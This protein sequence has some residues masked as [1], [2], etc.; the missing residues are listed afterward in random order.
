MEAL[1]SPDSLQR[2]IEEL[3]A[4]AYLQDPFDMLESF[5]ELLT[6]QEDISTV[7]CAETRVMPG[8]EEGTTVKY[9]RWQTPYNIAPQD[10]LDDLT[11]T[12]MI[13]VKPSRSGGTTIVENYLFK[14]IKHGPMGWTSLVLNSDEA[15]SDYVKTVIKPM[16]ELN[17]DIASRVSRVK[18]ENND[19]FK[20]IRGSPVELLS[21]KDSTF[22]N[23]QPY[24]MALDEVDA[25]K[26]EFARSPVVQVDGR[27]KRLGNRRKAAILSHPDLG[28]ASGVSS[29][30]ADMSSRG[31]YVMRCLECDS[32][33]SAFATKFW[34]KV[35]SFKLSW[36]RNSAMSKDDRIDL[37]ERSAGMEC[38]HCGVML[39]EEQRLIMI[40]QAV[41]WGDK[42]YMHRGQTLHHL[43]GILGEMI[44]N[45]VRGYYV[46]GLMVKAE[47]LAKL[48]K[49]Y[50]NAL[51]DFENTRKPEKIKQFLS[52]QLAQIFEGG[53]SLD[54]INGKSLKDRAEL[55]G[56]PIG[57]FPPSAH[58]IT[59]AVDIGG[60][61]FDVSFYA[62]DLEGRSWL[63]D[64][65]TIMQREIDG[66]IRKLN[67]SERIEDWDV[68]IDQVVERKFPITGMKD[69]FMPVAV[70]VVDVSDG[71]VTAKG[72]SFAARCIKRGLYWGKRDAPWC[73]VQLVQGSP[74]K[75]APELPPKPRIAD[76]TGRR[77]I[78]GVQ[79]WSP[80][81]FKLK[82][83]ALE[84]LAVTD[85]G[86][87]YC[88]FAA[89]IE[90]EYFE[91][92][93]RE[94][95][96]NGEFER[97]GDQ[98]SFD[99]FGY[100]EAGRLMLDPDNKVYDWE[101]GVIPNWAKPVRIAP[102]DDQIV[103]GRA[104]GQSAKKSRLERFDALNKG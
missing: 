33:A 52:K 85:E 90:L 75:K 7:D 6:P 60:A 86:P 68:L 72:R 37:A 22:R 12:M 63:I 51:I 71:H 99:N 96:I 89:E 9:D 91:Q 23:R 79:E 93:F 92:F 50:E 73:R 3:A 36:T 40:D 39:T 98:E 74:S 20:K 5:I 56:L 77:F 43:E 18:G 13:M 100:A 41:N 48:A 84:R 97:Q 104:P 19:T 44:P 87:G 45:P 62:W 29:A 66:V 34:G 25:W 42:G 24:F 103:D 70:T 16:I 8:I 102:A 58:F 15:I 28:W 59:A 11:C 31:I 67:P 30:W 61:R 69:L 10:A 94:P 26:K 78:L 53:A 57:E 35:K 101:K 1:L 2:G 54:G 14:M 21:A 65:T 27:Q 64:R 38:P 4:S 80:G 49:D 32:F 55:E 95:L 82:E 47:T 81:V 76:K 17:P 88:R 46:H 83:Q